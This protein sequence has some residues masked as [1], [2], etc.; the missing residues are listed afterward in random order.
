[1]ANREGLAG[2]GFF[3]HPRRI[4]AIS[5]IWTAAVLLCAAGQPFQLGFYL[6][7]WP[8][9]AAAAHAGAPF[10]KA[11]LGFVW[12]IDPTRPGLV[13]LLFLFSSFF[14]DR[15]LLWHTG[16]LAAGCLVAAILIRVIGL[17]GSEKAGAKAA[18]IWVGLCWLLLP[19][20]VAAQFWPTYLPNV[21]TL[22]VFG[23]L[24]ALLIRGWSR[25]KHNAFAAFA[26]YL[27]ICL[28]YE[29]FYFQWAILALFGLALVRAGR[30][31]L[32]DVAASTIALI[33]AQLGALGW[34]VYSARLVGL[35]MVGVERTVVPDWPRILFGDLLTTI[36][37]IYRSF[38]AAARPFAVIALVFGTIWLFDCYKRLRSPKLRPEV[39]TPVVLAACC[40]AGGVL[41]IFAF[42]LGG[43]G[44]EG[45]GVATRTLMLFNFWI[46]IGAGILLGAF[47]DC[48]GRSM[49][50]AALVLLAGLGATLAAGHLLRLADWAAAWRLETKVLAQ[51]P[52]DELRKTPA[53]ARILLV[54]QP[55]VNGAPAFSVAWDL[56]YA[57]PWKYPFLEGRVF[58]VFS[59]RDGTLT[60][61]GRTLAYPGAAPIA[62]ATEL[63]VWKPAMEPA[64]GSF[65]RVSAPFRV[66][67]EDLRPASR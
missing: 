47:L 64:A 12:A 20:N 59:P 63:Y 23:W 18:A 54:N 43:R 34:H 66:S 55:S 17:A 10:S 56:N 67:V 30:A 5:A 39:S 15:V 36:P 52:V 48:A 11:L 46:L 58:L 28:G 38:G 35:G 22:A 57:M 45:T 2:G 42:A 7:D 27:W 19:W 14:R 4:G 44:I 65:S 51:A 60:W 49:R 33:A 13:P 3:A 1:M 21:F 26:I 25:H 53:N 37:S 61:D 32:R 31:R 9:C 6:D 16:L 29:A 8:Q 50:M 40:L 62:T 24:L 41:S